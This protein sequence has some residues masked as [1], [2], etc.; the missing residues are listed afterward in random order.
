[1]S[2]TLSQENAIR[3]RGNSVL[4]SAGAG[5][6]KTR[7]LTERL[8]DRLNPKDPDIRPADIDRFLI[9]T[10]TRAAAGEL[11]SRIADAIAERLRSDPT[12]AHLRRQLVLCRNAQIGTIHSFCG[13]LL[14]DYAGVLG[15]S[16]GFR[17]LEEER[18]ERLREAALERVLDRRYEEQREDFLRLIDRVGAGRDDTRLSVLVLKLHAAL[19]SHARPEKWIWDR[20]EKLGAEVSDIAET[21]WG[22]EL[23]DGAG[24]EADF[25][26]GEM[27][28]ALQKMQSEVKIRLAYE[29]SFSQTCASLRNLQESLHEGWDAASGCFPIPFPRINPI[30]N[31]PD[32]ELAEELKAVRKQCKTAMDKLSK[33]FSDS[34]EAMLAE[35]RETIPEMR[36]LLLLALDL[37]QEFRAAKHRVN[38]MDFS[39]LEH[40][41]IR[42]LTDEE[43]NQTDIARVVAERFDEVM[44]DEYQDVSRVQDQIFHAVSREGTNLF[45]VGDLKQS[46][47]RFRLADPGIFT[48]KSKYYTENSRGEQLIRL[49]ENF[50][51]RPEVLH[52]VNDVFER[53]MSEQLGDL[54]YGEE[55]ALIPGISFP[56]TW[57]KPELLLLS[58]EESGNTD[59]EAEAGLVA[60]E[61]RTLI[62]SAQVRE[63]DG[64]RPVR[65]GDMA[66]LLRSANTIGP[67]FRRV[68]QSRGIPVTAG[69]CGDFYASL[70][71]STVFAM[72]SI[73]DNPH[74]DIP[75]L[76][77]LNSPCFDFSADSLSLI[78]AES[79]DTDYY[80]ALG[81]SENE[82]AKRFLRLLSE[83]RSEAPDLNVVE[84]VNLV[85]EQLDLRAICSAMPDG[86]QRLQH[87][88]DLVGMAESFRESGEAGLHRFVIWLESMEK[89]GRDPKSCAQDADAVQLMSIHRSKGLEFP[90]VFCSGL[91]RSFNRQDTQDTVLIHPELGLGPKLTDPE[92][93]IEYPTAA[94][95]AIERR[96]TREML[97]EE[98]RLLYVAMTR[99]KDHLILTAFVKKPEVRITE[100]SRLLQYGKIPALLLRSASAPVQWVLPAAVSGDNLSLR[101][102]SR[103]QRD[104]EEVSLSSEK[105]QSADK[106]LLAELDHNLTWVY[107][108]LRAEQLPS[109][110]TATEL[111]GLA[112]ADPDAVNLEKPISVRGAFKEL[113]LR[114]EKLSATELGTAVHLVLQQIDLRHTDSVEAIKAE[115]DRLRSQEY[116]T[117][118]ESESIQAEQILAFFASPLGSRIRVAEKLWREFRF[119]LMT[120]VRELLP[121]ETEQEKVLLQGVVD[122]CFEEDGKLVLVDYKT[123]RVS[124]KEQIRERAEHYRIQ[125][126]TY[127]RALERIFGLPVKEKIL[128]FIRPAATLWL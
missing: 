72:L 11:R 56:D 104:R 127:S 14:R 45:F 61:I 125:L 17:I 28:S 49:R 82:E 83:L 43:G 31:N 59:L 91:G 95:R 20:I 71:V 21:D 109:K 27:E 77:V 38:A 5:S 55:D 30:R 106:D 35:L 67:V 12:N 96:L 53:A 24:E 33:V 85:I 2:F 8:M 51:S 81:V 48:E 4:V 118:E 113:D 19:Q 117:A 90:V 57:E 46:I 75:L 69:T 58:G 114:E 64:I 110:L 93:K 73:M 18:G 119:S 37:E 63:G 42:L 70:E 128:Y 101:L 29:D 123:D 126:E 16:S 86:E 50:R 116:L 6:G 52:A 98:M 39:D 32:P 47:Y 68:L 1:M 122:C 99:A 102:C 87:L 92:N 84:L 107:P 62:K 120:D 79:P 36:E 88:M 74:R 80:T 124:G 97:S 23:M 3:F 40:F 65:Y 111:K 115:I 41:A 10:F 54:N 121:G 78:R 34:S 7:V 26:K 13:Q 112:S 76:A 66:I 9:I 103:E 22:R 60:D 15:I 100:A 44:V 94:R 108:H 105:T 89:Q 25:W